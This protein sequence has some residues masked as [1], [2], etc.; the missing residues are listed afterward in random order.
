M[1]A[2]PEMA[3]IRPSLT[4]WSTAWV[5]E[6]LQ[7][8]ILPTTIPRNKE[9]YTSFVIRANAI[10]IIGGTSAQKVAV[11]VV[12]VAVTMIAIRTDAI[13]ASIAITEVAFFFM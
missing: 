2:V 13:I 5:A 4:T 12:P 1:P 8:K 11:V 9:E 3:L 7:A 6:P 10:A